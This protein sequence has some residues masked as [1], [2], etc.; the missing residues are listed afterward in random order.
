MSN[1]PHT[2]TFSNSDREAMFDD[3]I[4]GGKDDRER[5]FLSERCDILSANI[6]RSG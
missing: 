3:E 5:P 4:E 1:S 6:V 2:L